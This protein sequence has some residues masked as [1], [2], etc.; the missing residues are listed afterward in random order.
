MST[1]STTPY[2]WLK[3]LPQGLINIDDIP[4]VGH[5]PPFPWQKFVEA[6]QKQF[7]IDKLTIT[8]S[9]WK[10]RDFSDI[11]TGITGYPHQ[12]QFG[13]AGYEGT[14]TLIFDKRD[15][16]ATAYLLLLHRNIDS[17]ILDPTYEQALF[18]FLTIAACDQF[19]NTNWEKGVQVHLLPEAKLKETPYLS[20]DLNI[21][22][23]LR[24]YPV[25]LLLDDDLRQSWKQK[26]LEPFSA[27][28]NP[29]LAKKIEIPVG[30]EAGNLHMSTSE[31]QHVK[32][33]DFITLDHC[34]V[35]PNLQEGS[36]LLRIQHL[37]YFKAQLSEGNIILQEQPS[38]HEIESAMAKNNDDDSDFDFDEESVNET[39]HTEE[40]D[41][42]FDDDS[43]FDFDDE[44]EENT[45]ADH[46]HAD[47]EGEKEHAEAAAPAATK[48]PQ[49]PAAPKE[50]SASSAGHEVAIE[51]KD[52]LS[53][54]PKDIPLYIAVEVG[55]FQMTIEKMME[56]QPGNML[57]LNI[58][59]EDG[60]DL[61]VNGRRI[62]RGE[63]LKFGE[64]LGVRIT[65][66]G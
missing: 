60:V 41:F 39:E 53:A 3:S 46:T 31:W 28:I 2:D 66:I 25:R 9:Q 7:E 57:N 29:E 62:G 54:S 22:L 51:K 55:R 47:T 23:P 12:L 6:L 13:V 43:D 42:D 44:S 17:E 40:S 34:T 52:Q 33:G 50:A 38:Y 56:L 59:P 32:L 37:P 21:D 1:P 11:L 24:S 30:I 48:T 5:A 64:T 8:P 49:K 20:L 45:T 27:N 36:L 63:L 18:H 61:V 15:F 14:A 26:H 4:M 19:T 58:R 16:L 10:W 65:E 35:E